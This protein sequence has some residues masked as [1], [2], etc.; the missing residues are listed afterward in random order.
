MSAAYDHLP[1]YLA[2]RVDTRLGPV[3]IST[4]AKGAR[5][6]LQLIEDG[7]F[8][9]TNKTQ[10]QI[11]VCFEDIIEEEEP[12]PELSPTPL[13]PIPYRTNTPKQRTYAKK[14][15]QLQSKTPK[16][17]KEKGRHSAVQPLKEERPAQKKQ[18]T[19]YGHRKRTIS[20]VSSPQTTKTPPIEKELSTQA[21]PT[22]YD[23]QDLSDS[24][25]LLDLEL[26]ELPE[27]PKSTPAPSYN[28][29]A[30]KGK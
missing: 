13:T 28:L 16:V 10:I 14:E 19:S 22:L 4:A 15:V 27:E 3:R 11:C 8:S 17:K 5:T 21:E 18:T 25:E 7:G 2:T 26:P 24:S 12:E 20:Q 6:V 29:R 30:K 9:R 1:S 23:D